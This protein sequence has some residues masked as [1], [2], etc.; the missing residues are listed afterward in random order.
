M[1]EISFTKK[2]FIAAGRIAAEL[3][4][5]SIKGL[6]YGFLIM[7][8]W[9]WLMPSISDLGKITWFQAW[10]LFLLFHILFK[11][12]NFRS[13]SG[14]FHF[15]SLKRHSGSPKVQDNEWRKKFF[16]DMQK[17]EQEE[18]QDDE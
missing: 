6:I 10:G 1:E 5:V 12:G 16:A 4:S 17:Q 11:S 8:L 13:R 18:Q 14:F 15:S 7:P 9:N 2:I 3:L